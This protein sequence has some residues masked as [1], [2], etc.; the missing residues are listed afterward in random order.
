M[1]GSVPGPTGL[2][3]LA[4][5]DGATVVGSVVVGPGMV[6]SGGVPSGPAVSEQP[7]RRVA[8]INASAQ[9]RARVWALITLLVVCAS[10]GKVKPPSPADRTCA[11]VRFSFP[12][13]PLA[14]NAARSR[15]SGC[16]SSPHATVKSVFHSFMSWGIDLPM[17]GSLRHQVN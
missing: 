7:K 9:A 10:D 6:P 12:L 16:V 5:G 17:M 4:G 15:A 13:K 8:G 1:T 2:T 3:L 14:E 11:L